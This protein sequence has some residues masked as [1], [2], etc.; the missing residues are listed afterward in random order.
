[1]V[2]ISG[3][4]PS[5]TAGP[6][7]AGDARDAQ[8]DASLAKAELGWSARTALIDGMRETYDYFAAI[9]EKRP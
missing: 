4:E 9:N 7:R 1:L 2:G 5:V 6:K 3:F 8:F